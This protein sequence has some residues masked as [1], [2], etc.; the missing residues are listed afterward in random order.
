M[1]T[2]LTT[3]D[4]FI[5]ALGEF[6]KSGASGCA[7]FTSSDNHAG[8]IIVNAGAITNVIYAVQTGNNALEAMTDILRIKYR[9]VPVAVR[10]AIDSTLPTTD[11]ILRKLASTD[12]ESSPTDSTGAKLTAQISKAIEE[13]LTDVIGPMATFICEEHLSNA[14]NEAEVITAIMAEITS[15]EMSEFQE[16]YNEKRR[17]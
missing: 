6:C 17:T 5:K 14:T 11:I 9:F 4:E 3:F 10:M 12:G 15:D 8:R 7:F 16:I 1:E 13:S 2:V